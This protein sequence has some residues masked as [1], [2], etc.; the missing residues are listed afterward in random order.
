MHSALTNVLLVGLGSGLGG[1]LRY[2]VGCAIGSRSLF[3]MATLAV[4]VAGALLLGVLSGW[5][6]R[7]AAAPASAV[8]LLAVV[9]FCG[10]FTTFSTFSNETFQML[11]G[12][13]WARAGI[14][15]AVSCLAGIG[16]VCLGYA[17]SR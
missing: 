1:A 10:S 11:E 7:I 6:A 14:Y 8:R 5:I 3:P 9:G 2:L 12:G 15:V 13:Q 17:I 4:N 16:A